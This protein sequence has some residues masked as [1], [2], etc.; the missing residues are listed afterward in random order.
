MQQGDVLFQERELYLV[1]GFLLGLA[2][3]LDLVEMG[4]SA[5]IQATHLLLID[6]E[7]ATLLQGRDCLEGVVLIEQFVASDF[8]K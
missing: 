1:V 2:Q 6:F 5:M 3:R 8:R 4:L 7:N